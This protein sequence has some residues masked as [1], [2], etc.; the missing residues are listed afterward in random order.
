VKRTRPGAQL[1][2]L[3]DATRFLHALANGFVVLTRNVRDFDIMN[4]ILPGGQVM[5]Y[6]A[7]P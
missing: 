5:F 6:D 4:Q 7:A 3:N 1:A 2:A